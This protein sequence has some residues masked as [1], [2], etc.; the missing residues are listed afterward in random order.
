M[1]RYLAVFVSVSV[2]WFFP[3]LAQVTPLTHECY[4][5]G[6]LFC[7][8]FRSDDVDIFGC[9]DESFRYYNYHPLT[10][11]SPA[12]VTVTV[13]GLSGF[14]PAVA[15]QST[16][17][18]LDYDPGASRR[19]NAQA[20]ALILVPGEYAVIVTTY[21]ELDFGPYTVK[22]DC[23]AVPYP[24]QPSGDTLPLLGGR[25][26]V[27]LGARDHR[28]GRTASGVAIPQND[29]FG[30]FSIPGLTG[31]VN[32]PEIFVKVIDGRAVN[33]KFW[34][35]YGGL[36]DL[37]FTLNVTDVSTNFVRSYFKAGGSACGAYD[38]IAF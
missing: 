11:T 1:A 31:D 24:Q 6:S 3:A 27:T 12:I 35:F 29:L 38:T 8:A 9:K 32:N 37:E 20:I 14:E 30:Y 33:G 18:V 10:L 26:R 21:R 36:T 4:R 23:A 25:F 28:S 22:V 34:V 13:N 7:S 16:Q 19:T 15:I 5:H 2:L 17:R